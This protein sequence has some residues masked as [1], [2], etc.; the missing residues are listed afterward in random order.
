MA[1]TAVSSQFI[2]LVSPKARGAQ[3]SEKKNLLIILT[4]QERAPMWFPEGWEEMNLPNTARLKENGLSFQRAYTAAAMCSPARNT[5]FT[6]LF[7]AQHRS[8][9]TLTE[10][11]LQSEGEHQL[12]PSLPNLATCLKE[13]GYDV[14]YKGKWHMSKM[15]TGA[16]GRHIDDDISRYGF[17]GWDAPDAGGDASIVNFGGG[18]AN[19]DERFVSDAVNFLESRIGSGDDRPFC[20][21]VSLVNPHDVLGYPGNY[22]EGGYTDDPWLNPTDPPIQLPPT[23]DED[24]A[25][26]RKPTAQRQLLAVMQAGLGPVVTPQQKSR[27]INFYGNLMS[28]VDGQIGRL[29][30]VFD[31][32]GDNGASALRD[33]LIIRTSDHGEMGMCHGGLRQKTFN[34]YEE[35]TRI[36][37][38]WSNPEL[39]PQPR[40]SDALV[41]HVDFLPTVCSLTGVPN[42]QAKGFQG[43]DYSSIILDASAPPVQDYVLFTFD[44]IYAGSDAAT[45]PNGAVPPPNRLQSIRTADYKFTRYFDGEGVEPDQQEF[46]DLRPAGG[47][48][49]QNYQLPLE[50]KNLSLWAAEN[51]PNPTALTAEQE[52]AR[53]QLMQM[54]EAAVAE[55]LQPRPVGPSTAPGD[56]TINIHDWTDDTGAARSSVE[57]R[58]ISQFGQQYQVQVSTDLVKWVDAGPPIIGNNGPV[59][60]SFDAGAPHSFYRI[61]YGPAADQ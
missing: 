5:L 41:S 28:H 23:T 27:Y 1:A 14:I 13:A 51:F 60:E 45:V 20:L 25:L 40:S 54:L 15:V 42:W 31:E 16:D 12:D 17:D 32:K 34:S 38:I 18:A 30:S 50:M 26:N 49:D 35:T 39:F 44:D 29:L 57:I 22:I 7:P 59:L 43:V 47:D 33:T 3:L 19:H 56:L 11:T 53:A 52:Q 58:F 36:P 2:G 6:G 4:D 55:R 61:Q 48:Y 46:Y 10:E 8:T 37:L 9:D 24:L 21:I